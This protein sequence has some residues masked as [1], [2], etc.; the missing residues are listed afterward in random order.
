[1]EAAL[2]V[3]GRLLQ[4]SGALV[5]FGSPLFFLYGTRGV[6]A[7]VGNPARA[8]WQ[9]R[10]VLIGALGALLG[11][12]IWVMAETAAMSDEARDAIRPT[13]LWTILSDTHFGRACLA[14]MALLALSIV[15]SLTLR[16]T[17]A[18]WIVLTFLGAAAT[19]SFAWTGHGAVD[20][21][22]GGVIHLGGDLLHLLAAGVWIG[23]LVPLALM[24]RRSFQAPSPTDAREILFGLSQ[25]SRIGIFVVALLVLSGAINSWFLIGPS[26]WRSLFATAYGVTLLIKLGLFG[27]MLALAT[28]NRNRHTP[29]LHAA[30]DDPR[31]TKTMLRALRGTVMSET[32]LALVVLCAVSLLGTLAPPIS[33]V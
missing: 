23:A 10:L 13:A 2:L 32:I 19:A 24:L 22:L 30:I 20:R 5:L 8:P 25:F 29:A 4:F 7:L 21:G 11:A 28:V 17:R 18:L 3:G 9:R 16:P 14:R 6:P 1:M 12:V 33:G 15:A 31:A 27:I 26:R